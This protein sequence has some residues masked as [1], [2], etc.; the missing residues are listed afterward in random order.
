MTPRRAQP[1]HRT[2]P[3]EPA[4]GPTVAAIVRRQ[5]GAA[6]S[7]ARDLCTEGRVTVNGQRCLDSASRVPS[8][9]EVVVD[10]HAPKLRTGVLPESSIVFLDRDVVVVDKPP[11][12][13]TVAYEPRDKDTLVD[14]TRTLLRR[15][16]GRGFDLGLGVVHRLDKDTSGV[17]VF[18]RTA[19]A[20]RVLAMRFRAHDLERVYHAIAHG[21]VAAE[22]IETHLV[23]DRGDGLRG[24]YGHFRRPKGGIPPEAKRSVTHVK[25]IAPLDGATLVECRLE[26]GRQHQIRIHLAELGHPLVGERVY[27]RDYAGRK[28]ESMRTM[29]HARILGFDHPRTGR[30]MSF[31]R[32]A[33]EDFRAMLESL[34]PTHP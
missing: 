12:M 28:V 13:L 6:W 2:T 11:G 8:G 9:A 20:K 24:S 17:I 3:P 25:P 16:H 30:R 27:V 19:E 5:T 15:I 14:C 29:L 32:E 26:T 1:A 7:R 31:E 4:V 34:R 22:R 33:P 10:E 23:L 18:A 21:A